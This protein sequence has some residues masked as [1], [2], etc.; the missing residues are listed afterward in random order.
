MGNKLTIHR[1]FSQVKNEIDLIDKVLSIYSI[2]KF[3]PDF[4]LRNYEKNILV[5]YVR[6]GISDETLSNIC[7]DKDIN[8][9]Y[10]HKI[11]KDLRDKGFLVSSDK[12][13]RKF[14]LSS[15]LEVIRQNFIKDKFK[16]YLITFEK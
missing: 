10:L 4:R 6:K 11:N 8:K 5:Y 15:D 2:V 9:N 13:L 12:N 14:H 3:E 7:E 16:N 1:N